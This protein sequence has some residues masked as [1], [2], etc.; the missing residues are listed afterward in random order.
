M[1]PNSMDG[2]LEGIKVLDFSSLLP[3][4]MATLLLAEAGAS[5][6]KIERPNLGDEMRNF[7]SKWDPDSISFALLNKGKKSLAINL[8]EKIERDL[9]IPLIKETDVVVEQ[10]RPGVM[11]KLGLGYKMMSAIKH[12]IIYCS[13]TGYGQ[14]GPKKNIAGHDLNYISDTGLL[15]LSMGEL[16]NPVIPPALIADIAG[17]TYPAVINI[18]LALRVRDLHKKGS[19]IDIA[20]SEGL[21]PFMFW[22][23]GRGNTTGNWPKN[24]DSTFTG[25]SPRYHLYRTSDNKILAAAPLEQKFWNIFCDT[26]KLE[27]RFRHDNINP[28][29]TINEVSKIII[30]KP[31]AYWQKYFNK[32]N[33]CC[34]IVKTIDS[35][36]RDPQFKSRKLFEKKIKTL[37]GQNST[38]L[39]L[40]INPIFR[41]SN[42][43]SKVP[44]LKN[45]KKINF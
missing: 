36:M 41:R 34:S 10:F 27:Y 39:P 35:A 30:T 20:M 25:G 11:E 28:R 7:E 43:S 17:G 14:T 24:S 12:D 44:R 13:I 45:T 8:K 23:I 5:V 31:A 37:S 21:F 16:N 33:C 22:A 38:A 6:I 19:H 3:G 18:L 15:A 4:P 9:L 26:I 2:A 1:M 32:A 42:N 29:L 40:P